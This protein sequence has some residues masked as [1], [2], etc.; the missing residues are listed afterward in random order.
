MPPSNANSGPV[1]I[2]AMEWLALLSK[3]DNRTLAQKLIACVEASAKMVVLSHD[4][5]SQLQY[6][7]IAGLI[8]FVISS[9]AFQ[10]PGDLAE[11]FVRLNHPLLSLVSCSHFKTTD[12]H[13]EVVRH[14]QGNFVKILALYSARNSVTFDSRTFFALEPRLSSIWYF[15]YAQLVYSGVSSEI[16]RRRL[17][18]HF[19]NPPANLMPLTD[20]QDAYFAP[21]Y[22]DGECERTIKGHVNQ[23]IRQLH[24]AALD[25]AI[26]NR[27]D[28]ASRRKIAVI[29]RNWQ[30]NHSVYRICSQLIASLRPHYHLTLVQCGNKKE[31]EAAA[32]DHVITLPERG[33]IADL[34]PL[35]K[36]DFHAVLYPDA[37]MSDESVYLANMRLA[38]IQAAMPGHPVSTFGS[39]LDYFIT[40]ADVETPNDPGQHYSERL[41]LLPGMG[42]THNRPLWN[43]SFLPPAF[44]ERT[45][46]NVPAFGQKI[47]SA[48]LQTLAAMARSATRPVLFRLFVGSVIFV[49]NDYFVFKSQVAEIL[50]EGSFEIIVTLPYD[51]YMAKI[52]DG[53]FSLDA[54]HF[55]GGNSVSDSLFAGVPILCRQGERWYNR[56]G[57][58][59]LRVAGLPQLIADTEQQFIDLAVRL[60]GEEGWQNELR[61][62][63][64]QN[65]LDQTLY[66]SADAHYF[67]KAIDYLLANHES[68]KLDPSREPIRIPRDGS[69]T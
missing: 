46:I 66:S 63:L 68:L 3:G 24:G 10:V 12:A 39:Q 58:Q 54:W 14:Q 13:L 1:T 55:G 27:P 59:M 7:N 29:T 43:P 69:A 38:P 18:A 56:I 5:A 33:A 8:L 9:P 51:E 50:P 15:Q 16:V 21:T 41:V 30:K 61:Q 25:L 28:P 11:A 32:F 31:T 23:R 22:V 62:T 42:C 6:D 48:Y 19:E 17:A 65:N 45:I 47:N 26:Q 4:P 57:A 44:G 64:R 35:F 53:H 67:R 34:A 20:V 49:F 2:D 36:N 37:G 60:I 40:G 52:A